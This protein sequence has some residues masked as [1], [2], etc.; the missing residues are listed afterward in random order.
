MNSSEHIFCCVSLLDVD[1]AAEWSQIQTPPL[2]HL[3]C[4]VTVRMT[5]LA[6]GC[7]KDFLIL[8]VTRTAYPCRHD[9]FF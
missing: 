5:E 2:M 7:I 8:Q 9:T 4:I 6:N 3:R 1:V